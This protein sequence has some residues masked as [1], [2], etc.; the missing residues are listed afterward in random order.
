MNK[1]Y[2]TDPFAT[3]N[4]LLGKNYLESALGGVLGI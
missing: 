1:K 3:V 4:S 2:Q